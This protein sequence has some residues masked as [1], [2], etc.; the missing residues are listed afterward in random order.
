MEIVAK[1]NEKQSEHSA[2]MPDSLRNAKS[3]PEELARMPQS[4]GGGD[5]VT[6]RKCPFLR[7]Q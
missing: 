1:N 7:V 5:S 3:D 4:G 2:D 6:A